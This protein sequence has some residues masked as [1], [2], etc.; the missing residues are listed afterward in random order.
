MKGFLGHPKGN[1]LYPAIIYNRGGYGEYGVLEGWEVALFVE[2]GY[3]AVASQYRGNAGSEGKEQFG[4]RDVNDVLNLVPLLKQFPYVDPE[5][6]G[7]MGHGSRIY[8][9]RED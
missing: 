9:F 7:M 4:G 2:A 3:V 6:I 1:G 5:R 8:S